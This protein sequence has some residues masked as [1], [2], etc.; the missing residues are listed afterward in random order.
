MTKNII[1]FN[2]HS[3]YEAFVE[4][5]EYIEPHVSLCQDDNKVNY[6]L[7]QPSFEMVDLG[8]SSGRK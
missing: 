6:N 3:D 8:L 1:K 2:T 5:E 4:S 7:K